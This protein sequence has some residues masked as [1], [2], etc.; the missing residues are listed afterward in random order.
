M[1]A[2]W[3]AVSFGVACGRNP[4]V[5]RLAGL[6]PHS[7]SFRCALSSA[8]SLRGPPNTDVSISYDHL[9]VIQAV[10]SSESG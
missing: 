1:G 10:G 3:L 6:T 5:L 9:V 8:A 7:Q 2:G 4:V